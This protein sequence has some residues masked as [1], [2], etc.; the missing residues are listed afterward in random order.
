MRALTALEEWVRNQ[1]VFHSAAVSP[2]GGAS[3]GGTRPKR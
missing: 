1:I 2:L 3:V